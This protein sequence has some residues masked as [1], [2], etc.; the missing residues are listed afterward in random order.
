MKK[1]EAHTYYNYQFKHTA[2]SVTHHPEIQ[3]VHVA[4][5]LQI[6]PIMLYRWRQEM[7]AGK[8]KDNDK[9][10]RSITDIQ[11]AQKENKK[12]KREIKQL[13]SENAV[14]KKAERI[15]PGKK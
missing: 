13:R 1:K 7:R 11:E 4:E 10:A 2:V 8:I 9:S 5:A 3:S 12:L 15:F 6:H 14:L